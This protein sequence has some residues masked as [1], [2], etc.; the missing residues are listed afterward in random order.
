MDKEDVPDAVCQYPDACKSPAIPLNASDGV[1]D[2][3]HNKSL[4]A[5]TGS[6]LPTAEKGIE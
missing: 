3:I 2:A 4:P 6:N 5:Q 1:H